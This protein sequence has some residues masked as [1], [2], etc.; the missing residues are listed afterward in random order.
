MGTEIE[1]LSLKLA[2]N[3]R[4]DLIVNR[5]SQILERKKTLLLY[6]STYGCFKKYTHKV[7]IKPTNTQKEDIESINDVDIM[8][9]T[10]KA[11]P[12][13]GHQEINLFTTKK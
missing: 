12:T 4:E 11:T 13:L 1:I 10:K 2:S 9:N 5:E 7:Y 8:S 6:H 3:A